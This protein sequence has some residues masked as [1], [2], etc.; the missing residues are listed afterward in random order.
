MQNKS[1]KHTGHMVL[2]ASWLAVFCLFAFRTTFAIFQVPMAHEMHWSATQISGGFAVMMVVYALSAF[3]S[4]W[5]VDRKGT[6]PAYFFAAIFGSLSYLVTSSTHSLVAYYAAYGVLGGI[7]TGML[8]VSSTVSVRKWFAGKNYARM[9]GLVFMGAPV[10]QIVMSFAFRHLIVTHGWRFC[11]RIL[12]G[13]VLGA[14]L[15]SS[16]LARKNPEDYGIDTAGP[17]P[18]SQANDEAANWSIAE[19]F[20]HRAMWTVIAVY[21]CC[22]VAEFL[23]WSQTVS[24]FIQDLKVSFGR[25]LAMSSTIGITGLFSMPLLGIVADKIVQRVGNEAQGRKFGIITASSVGAVS[26]AA[27]LLAGSSHLFGFIA[28]FLF[29]IY[30]SFSQ[31]GV[32]GYAGAIY[33][34]RYLGRIWSFATLICMG[35]GPALG[36]LLGA[37]LRDLTGSY[38][39]S[40]LF[41]LG[42]FAVSTIAAA[43]LPH[44]APQPKTVRF[45]SKSSALGGEVALG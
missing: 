45:R 34:S 36:S 41:A 9:W 37:Y 10:A 6:R 1:A 38:S 29:A 4:G 14:M 5:M 33:G 26:C 15:L 18:E 40:F 11:G 44:A 23:I 31:S 32:V 22:M 28:C 16:A 21:L 13:I 27:M 2:A 25:A 24:Y 43:T 7:G 30:M 19:T 42:A 39:A 8:W 12:S 20:S 35:I 3:L 17:Q